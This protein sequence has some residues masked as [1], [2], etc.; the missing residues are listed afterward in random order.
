MDAFL[1]VPI[2]MVTLL[3][4]GYLACLMDITPLALAKEPLKNNLVVHVGAM[5]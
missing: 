3:Y 1:I 2:A 4:A 5:T